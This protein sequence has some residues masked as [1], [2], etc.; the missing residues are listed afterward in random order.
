MLSLLIASLSGCAPNVPHPGGQHPDVRP[1]S[2][3]VTN[4]ARREDLVLALSVPTGTSAT[5]RLLSQ[6]VAGAAEVDDVTRWISLG[7]AWSRKARESGDPGYW[8][9]V[10]ACS[11]LA[12]AAGSQGGEADRLDALVLLQE[13]R[14]H[15]A[16]EAAQGLLALDH[17]DV[18]ALGLLADA[19]LELGDL[20]SA[21][22][23]TQRMVD[24]RPGLAS[25]GRSAWL[26]W[27]QGD[28]PG[29]H[30]LYRLALGAGDSVRDPE[31]MAWIAVQDALAW[32][33][34]GQL[35]EAS[36]SVTIAL[37]LMPDHAPALV[38]AARIA[39]S[40]GDASKAIALAEQALHSS[41]LASTAWLLA[42][43][44]R[45]I[46]DEVAALEAEDRVMALARADSRTLAAFL[47]NR[48]RDSSHALALI[49][50]ELTERG[51]PET[52]DVHAWALYR[53]GRFED[54]LAAS[55]RGLATGT[56]EALLLYHAGAIR[57]AL[58]R[59]GEGLALI[60][61]ALSLN[62]SFDARSLAEIDAMKRSPL[63]Q[64]D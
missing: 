7:R 37:D 50:D 57:V 11:R 34:H 36:Q 56:K 25:Y 47:A 59:R 3:G 9:S 60:E 15:A 62:P 1:E 13:H 32:W 6:L 46:G 22:D 31:A 26:A 33:Q 58:G 45:A 27:L 44:R 18:E 14:F 20:E 21:I 29:T 55:D 8:L 43:A 42:D 63:A 39:L 24:L 53:V 52:E 48:D 54:A 49:E 12:R 38:M 41:P 40:S 5:D 10:S 64:R 4:P 28:A 23:A 35:V 61:A 17:D 19:S 16:R 51:G 30:E 2:A